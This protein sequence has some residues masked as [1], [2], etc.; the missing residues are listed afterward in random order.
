MPAETFR[1]HVIGTVAGIGDLLGSLAGMTGQFL[2]G[3]I[4]PKHGYGLVFI[5][6]GCMHS[7]AFLL[8]CSYIPKLVRFRTPDRHEV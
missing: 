7:I 8:V 4:I 1:G 6:A 5:A 3:E 2:L